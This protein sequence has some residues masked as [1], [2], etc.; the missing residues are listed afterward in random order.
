MYYVT[1]VFD[2]SELA[3]YIGRVSARDYLG[4]NAMYICVMYICTI[5]NIKNRSHI[6]LSLLE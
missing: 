3:V 5:I 2:D 1:Q 6:I 4:D